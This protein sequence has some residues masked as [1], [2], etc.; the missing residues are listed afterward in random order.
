MS[1]RAGNG[2]PC[3]RGT[4]ARCRASC[5]PVLLIVL[6]IAMLG[7]GLLAVDAGARDARR[8]HLAD[9]DAI[10]DHRLSAR[11]RA[12]CARAPAHH[13]RHG[14]RAR[15]PRRRPAG[16]GYRDAQPLS[17]SRGAL[18]VRSR[19][20]PLQGR[21]ARRSM[22]ISRLQI[23]AGQRVGARRAFGRR[24][25]DLR[26]ADPAPLRPRWRA[27]PDRRAGH[28]AGHA[29]VAARAVALVP[30]DPMLFHRSIAEN[31]AYGQPGATRARDR[32]G[33]QA[34]PCRRIH[35]ALPK[36]YATLVGERGVKLSGGERQRVAIARA[37]LAD[38]PILILDEATSS[39]DCQSE[40]LYPRGDGPAAGR[41]H[42][43]RHR[44]PA[45]DRPAARPHPGVRP[46]PDRRGRHAR[47]ADAHEG[48]VY[49]RLVETQSGAFLA[50]AAE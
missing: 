42:D 48:G 37:F 2:A 17:V 16:G 28:R 36:G 5:R 46:W 26:E 44:A 25:V 15:F 3:A 43:D 35:A 45:V 10:P 11:H 9:R 1:R 4:A 21:A 50:E 18:V 33:R 30:Q 19:D 31:I 32:R 8:H 40:T 12:A 29:G 34:R 23:P 47:G 49:R 7:T 13:Q 38:A 27:H 24:Q 14:R 6:Q 39:L 41:A 22:T 20:V